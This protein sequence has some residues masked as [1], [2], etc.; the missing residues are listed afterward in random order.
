MLCYVI[1]WRGLSPWVH[2]IVHHLSSGS[3]HLCGTLL[4]VLT[5]RT[6]SFEEEVI[7]FT[8]KTVVANF[9]PGHSTVCKYVTRC[10]TRFICWFRCELT[11]RYCYS[12]GPDRVTLLPLGASKKYWRRS[13]GSW[14]FSKRI[15]RQTGSWH[16]AEM[17]AAFFIPQQMLPGIHYSFFLS[18]LPQWHLMLQTACSQNK[19]ALLDAH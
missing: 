11:G 9:N 7:L 1:L 19:S 3:L 17:M 8:G 14:M 13:R 4:Y 18:L 6:C 5:H 16:P 12:C 10:E 2:S 15:C